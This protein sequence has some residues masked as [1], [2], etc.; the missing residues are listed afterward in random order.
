MKKLVN[1][2]FFEG[3]FWESIKYYNIFLYN[4]KVISENNLAI[5]I[6]LL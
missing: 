2:Y 1:Y 4:L 6:I 3:I 5:E